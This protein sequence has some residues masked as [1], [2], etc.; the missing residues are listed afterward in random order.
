MIL[1][2]RGIDDLKKKIAQLLVVR[3]S[4][5]LYDS[6]RKYPAWELS[7]QELK[8]LLD[9]GLGGV[10]LHG[11]SVSELQQRCKLLKSWAK[12]SILLCADVEEGVGQ[13]FHGGSWLPPPM[14][15]GL[16]ID[17]LEMEINFGSP[18]SQW[19]LQLSNAIV[20]GVMFSFILTLIITPCLILIGE[21]S[22]ISK[23]F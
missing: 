9:N 19:W 22:K 10:I 17:F 6:Q 15:I 16:N 21:K 5:H 12:S 3:A 13:R 18:S 7:N 23:F 11:G 8:D 4:G 14:A 1:D 2:L 20:F